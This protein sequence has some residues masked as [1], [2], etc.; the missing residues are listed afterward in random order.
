[1]SI[2][3]QENRYA[4]RREINLGE[5]CCDCGPNEQGEEGGVLDRDFMDGEIPPG[6][7]Y[8]LPRPPLLY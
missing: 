8:A 4:S 5:C 7:T 2:S 3:L 6:Q 1:M